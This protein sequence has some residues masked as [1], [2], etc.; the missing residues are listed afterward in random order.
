MARKRSTMADRHVV[1]KQCFKD[2]AE[3]QGIAVTFMAKPVNGQVC[4]DAVRCRAMRA[5]T[6]ARPPCSQ[7]GSGCH[8]H[9]SLW[10]ADGAAAFVGTKQLGGGR[11]H[12]S[13]VFRWFLGG[14]IAHTREA[15]VFYA[16]NPNSYKRYVDESWAPTRIAWCFDNRTAGYRVV[17]HGRSLRIENRIPGADANICLAFAAC[18]AS[19]LDGIRRHLEPPEMFEGDIY[20]AQSLPSVP[21]TLGEALDAF[22]SSQW[23]RDAFGADVVAHYERLFSAE[24]QAYQAF[25]TDWEMRRY[26]ERI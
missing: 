18:L 7:S 9:I 5:L 15:M 22:R 24:L 26:F 20:A 11:I 3:Q 16:P 12:C 14:L 19:G 13:D 4:R 2:V 17:G 1:Y 6:P 21:R 8:I 10:S 25:V 23:A